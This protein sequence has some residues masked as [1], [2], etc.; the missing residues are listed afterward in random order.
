[1]RFIAIYYNKNNNS[2]LGSD[3]VTYIDGRLSVFNARDV[4]IAIG[5]DRKGFHPSIDKMRL[6]RAQRLRDIPE[7]S[8]HK[9]IYYRII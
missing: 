4:A 7:E 8:E 3:S 9:A 2:I 1:M 6:F 5:R